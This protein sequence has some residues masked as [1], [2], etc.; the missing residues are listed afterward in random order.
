MTDIRRSLKQGPLRLDF[1]WLGDRW[2][3]EIGLDDAPGP[4]V[5]AESV[6]PPSD[7][8]ECLISPAYQEIAREEADDSPWMLLGR[9]GRHHQSAVVSRLA[10]GFR[11]DVANRCSL[12]SP[13]VA[14]TYRVDLSSSDLDDASEAR[15]TWRV[16]QGRLVLAAESSSILAMAEAGR[17]STRVQVVAATG[18]D[19]RTQRLDYRWTWSP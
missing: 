10:D 5:R 6:D 16:G 14:A 17:R 12:A 3:H 7:R 18:P 1:V 4:I 11:F 19:P 8:P 2:T 13:R 15:I 9:A